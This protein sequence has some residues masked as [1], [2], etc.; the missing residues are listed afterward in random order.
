MMMMMIDDD[1]DDYDHGYS[2]VGDLMV[3]SRHR[4]TAAFKLIVINVTEIQN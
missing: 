4:Q 2:M 3:G 1:G